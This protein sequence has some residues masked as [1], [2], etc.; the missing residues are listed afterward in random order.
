MRHSI[1]LRCKDIAIRP[2]HKRILTDK[3]KMTMKKKNVMLLATLL[4]TVG[5]MAQQLITIA[6][7]GSFSVGGKTL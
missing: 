1:G 3:N 6:R 5:A 4:F 2:K 7:Q